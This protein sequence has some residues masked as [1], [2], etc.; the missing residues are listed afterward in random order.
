MKKKIIFG[1]SLIISAIIFIAIG[2]FMCSTLPNTEYINTVKDG[3]KCFGGFMSCAIGFIGL[4]GG[5]GMIADGL[6][7]F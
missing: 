6:D 2:V 3:L 4:L 1:I 7:I 5:I